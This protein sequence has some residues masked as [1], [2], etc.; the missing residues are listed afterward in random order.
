MLPIPLFLNRLGIG[1]QAPQLLNGRHHSHTITPQAR[2]LPVPRTLPARV[3][4]RNPF[5][6]TSRKSTF[7]FCLLHSAQRKVENVPQR[8]LREIVLNLARQ[9]GMKRSL[10][11]VKPVPRTPSPDPQ[12]MSGMHVEALLLRQKNTIVISAVIAMTPAT[13]HPQSTC[14]RSHLQPHVAQPTTTTTPTAPTSLQ[15]HLSPAS[16]ATISTPTAMEPHPPPNPLALSPCTP[17][18]A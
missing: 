11:E 5:I 2:T 13:Y 16:S 6:S 8:Q 17:N 14:R 1:L 4:R 3:T 9:A 18:S 10:L 12:N 7:P 15:P